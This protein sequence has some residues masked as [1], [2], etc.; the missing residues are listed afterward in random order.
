MIGR[1]RGWSLRRRFAVFGAPLLLLLALVLA[2]PTIDAWAR[3]AALFS[4]AVVRLPVRPITWLT[5][6][7]TRETVQW[8]ESGGRGLLVRP[9]GDDVAPA[10]VLVLG[11]DPAPPEDER[12]A[13]LLEALARTGFAVLLPL[14]EELDAKRVG[15]VEVERLVEAFLF[16]ER[17]DR[18]RDD[19]IAFL[20]LS[21]GGSL[22][23]VAAAD[24]RIADRVWFVQAIGPYY[25]AISLAASAL[26]AEH[27]TAE[28][29]EPWP[30]ARVTVDVIGETLLVALTE[31]QREALVGVNLESAERLLAEL[32]P[33]Q[34]ALLE[35]VS[36]SA[37]IEGLRAPL[38]LLHDRSDRFVPWTESEAL[39]A[40]YPPAVYHRLDLFEH[41]DPQVGN[42]SVLLRDGWR[43]MRLFSRIYADAR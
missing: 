13:R 14:S 39:A 3:S 8:G 35:A 20:G 27:R 18:V 43:L 38:Y 22:S 31:E 34:R 32:A 11:A 30:P 15:A 2:W 17:D 42:L 40:A 12:V 5:G 37:V 33:E 21:V 36:P 9:A 7:P 28:G 29:V 1:V 4:D 6:D 23:L 10:L 26:S 16:M 25:D 41:V 24:A 19:R